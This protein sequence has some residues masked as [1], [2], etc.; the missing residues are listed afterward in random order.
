[1]V[2]RTITAQD[3]QTLFDIA[4]EHCGDREAVF[5][6]IEM[7][8]MSMTEKIEAG[9]TIIIPAIYKKEVSA[10]YQSNNIHPATSGS[11]FSDDEANLITNDGENSLE[12]NDNNNDLI[13]N[14]G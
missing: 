7:N 13:E 12:T 8:D 6:I 4:I 14:N 5:S 11:D 2:M 10:Y 1:M 3:R 9:Q